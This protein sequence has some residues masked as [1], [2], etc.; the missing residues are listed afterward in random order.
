MMKTTEIILLALLPAL[1]FTSCVKDDLYNTPHP[2]RGAIL[3]TTDWSRRGEAVPVPDSYTV[4]VAGTSFTLQK[5][6]ASLPGTFEPGSTELLAYNTPA[7]VSI[8]GGTA[9]IAADAQPEVLFGGCATVDVPQDDTLRTTL[10]MYQLFRHVQFALTITGGDAGRISTIRAHLSGIASSIRLGTGEA[11]G[12]ATSIPIPFEREDRL[13]TA[14]L[15]LPGTIAGAEQHTVV[16]LTFTDGKEQA[17][18][19]D[20]TRAFSNFNANKLIP[21]RLSG[22]LYAPVGTEVGGS[23]IIEWTDVEGGDVDANM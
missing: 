15:W 18:D 23:T 12:T 14:A 2:D 8:S 19:T 17:V 22:S 6:V 3:L 11:T 7:G 4:E 21:L 20:V 16:T 1:A 5:P 9:T 10:A 13:L